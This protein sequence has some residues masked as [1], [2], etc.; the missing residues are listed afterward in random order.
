MQVLTNAGAL[1][2]DKQ[3]AVVR[4]L[5]DIV[6]ASA[7]DP[8]LVDRTWGQLTEAPDGGWGSTGTP[9]PARNSCS[10]PA[11]RSPNCLRVPRPRP[12]EEKDMSRTRILVVAALAGAVVIGVGSAAGAESQP[13][14]AAALTSFPAVVNALTQGKD[15]ELTTMLG[16]CSAPDGHTAGPEVVSGLH[17]Q[18]FQI[19]RNEFIA[20]SDTHVTLDPRNAESTEFIRYR[21]TPEGTVTVA[22]T[23]LDAG[24]HAQSSPVLTC[25]IGRGAEFH[26]R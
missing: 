19:P 18:A 21:V 26:S 20:F 17:I 10:P 5:T 12:D 22:V 14:E 4:E 9:T 25:E 11:P 3:I 6:A 15:V 16:Q 2:R 7:G 8:S 13:V 24:G 1:D 23:M